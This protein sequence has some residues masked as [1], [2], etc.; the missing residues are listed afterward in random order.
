MSSW[1]DL[2]HHVWYGELAKSPS[3]MTRRSR[4]RIRVPS[5]SPFTSSRSVDMSVSGLLKDADLSSAN[6]VP[7]KI[8]QGRYLLLYL[9]TYL[10]PTQDHVRGTSLNDDH[11][12][13]NENFHC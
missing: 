2:P 13:L 4:N 9:D 1:A 10:M 5:I 6:R 3:T 12:W 8:L 11:L 7:E